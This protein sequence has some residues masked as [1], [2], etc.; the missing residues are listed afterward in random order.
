MNQHFNFEDKQGRIYGCSFRKAN[1]QDIYFA[2]ITQWKSR[3]DYNFPKL[4]SVICEV[5]DLPLKAITKE[6]AIEEI[7]EYCLT[8]L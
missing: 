8:T 3:E 4:N 2:W 6:A 1:F 5:K 7:K